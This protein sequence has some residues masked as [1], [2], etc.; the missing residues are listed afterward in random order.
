MNN[1]RNK[2]GRNRDWGKNEDKKDD[3]DMGW[4]KNIDRRKDKDLRK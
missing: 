4:K 3:S 1:G 2:K